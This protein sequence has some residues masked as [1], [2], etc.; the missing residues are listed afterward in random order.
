MDTPRCLTVVQHDGNGLQIVK[1]IQVAFAVRLGISMYGGNLMIKKCMLCGKEF[2]AKPANRKI[3]YDDHYHPCPVCGKP[4]LSNNLQTQ[5]SCCSKECADVYRARRIKESMVQ[6]Y[7]VDNPSHIPEARQK[8]SKKSSA[9]KFN[10]TCIKCGKRFASNAPNVSLC[11]ECRTTTCVVCGKVFKMSWPYTSKTC[12]AECRAEYVKSR[13]ISKE[14]TAK[15]QQTLKQKYGESNPMFIPQVVQKVEKT[16]LERYGVKRALQKGDFLRKSQRTLEK[17]YGVR[18]PV[19]SPELRDKIT[20]TMIDKYGVDNYFRLPEHVQ[21]MMTSPDKYEDYISFKE[22]P[23]TYILEHYGETKPTAEQVCQDLGVTN[24]VIYDALIKCGVRDLLTYHVSSME[25]EVYSFLASIVPEQDIVRNDRKQIKPYELDLFIPR[26]NFAIEVNPS[27]T[28]NS[29][30]PDPWG[31]S[32]KAPNYHQMKSMMCHDVGIRLFHIFGYEWKAKAPILKSMIRS[33]LGCSP[34]KYFARN[35]AVKEVDYAEARK[36]LD[37]NHRQGYCRFQTAYGL[38]TTDGELVSL[39]TFGSPRPTMGRR[40]GEACNEV[41]LLRF[42]SKLDSQVVGGA[43]KLFSYFLSHNS[44]DS[45]VSFSDIAHTSGN[46]YQKLGFRKCSTSYPGYVWVNTGTE[47]Y[48]TRMACQKR[49]LKSLLKDDDIDIEGS[50]ERQ[51]M[52]EHGYVQVF[53]SG[54]IRWEYTCS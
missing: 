46:V 5:D 34:Y 4:V 26:C 38:Y 39:M 12:S 33:A 48:Y 7:G 9:R 40:T 3:C 22:N 10:C 50:T 54:T 30:N 37:T 27:C 13:G 16:M 44:Y 36:F 49:N 17:H 1:N 51:I 29:T 31:C 47:Q 6:K 28:H 35:L 25:Q 32:R 8:I 41:E 53:D 23:K 52:E 19:H 45:I 20:Q 2:D 43:S 24:T 21:A 11:E 14:R 42:C 15:A 18:S